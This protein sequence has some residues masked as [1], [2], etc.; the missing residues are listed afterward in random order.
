VAHDLKKLV[1]EKDW[2]VDYADKGKQKKMTLDAMEFLRRFMLHVLPQRFCK[3]RYYGILSI[4]NRKTK[5]ARCFELIGK[6]QLP[7]RFQ[8]LDLIR[9]LQLLTGIDYSICPCCQTGRM[10]RYN[11]LE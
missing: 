1:G 10:K 2:V 11:P 6:A 9:I 5:L 3:V 4:K 8:G 7:P